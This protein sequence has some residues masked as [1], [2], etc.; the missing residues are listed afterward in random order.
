MN[1]TH[2]VTLL[3][4]GFSDD[5]GRR[6]RLGVYSNPDLAQARALRDHR[7][8]AGPDATL[9]FQDT[10]NPNVRR[11]RAGMTYYLAITCD[12]ISKP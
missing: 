4:F 5:G 11:A 2:Q 6:T 9:T 3:Y 1:S 7:R 8:Q 12:V 10:S